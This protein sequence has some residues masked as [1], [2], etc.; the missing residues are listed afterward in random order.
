[1]FALI[2]ARTRTLLSGE[3][4][5]MQFLLMTPTWVSRLQEVQRVVRLMIESAIREYLIEG[6]HIE[7]SC[8]K[9]INDSSVKG[10]MQDC[11]KKKHYKRA[12]IETLKDRT[13]CNSSKCNDQHWTKA[14]VEEN[15]AK[16]HGFTQCKKWEWRKQCKIEMKKS[17]QICNKKIVQ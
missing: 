9:E 5:T 11:K 3:R 8:T 13:N 1:M 7:R 12:R 14:M 16:M 6:K 17:V 15:R 4:K 10:R 2:M